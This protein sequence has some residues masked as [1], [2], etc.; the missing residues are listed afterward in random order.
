MKTNF[1]QV[2]SRKGTNS[3]KWEFTYSDGVVSPREMGDD[4]FAPDE[5]LPLWVA[6]SDFQAPQTV[7]DAL[8]K[9][10]EHGMF[11]YS[12]PKQPYFDAIMGWMQRRHNWTVEKD[13]I[14]TAPGVVPSLNMIVQTFTE[15][16]ECVMIQTPVYFPFYSCVEN[17][18]RTL[19]HSPMHFNDGQYTMNYEDMDRQMSELDVKLMI[20]CSPH[21]PVGRV[22]S[23]EELCKL[24]ELCI[25]HDVIILSDEI[26]HDLIFSSAEF[27]TFANACPDAMDRTI[28]CT[29]P[30]K[31]FNVPGLKTSNIFIP[32]PE[33]REQM[34]TGMRNLGL[35][36]MNAFGLLAL[37]TAYAT[38]DEWVDEMMEYVVGNFDYLR[39]FLAEH[40]PDAKLIDAQGTYLAWVDFRAFGHDVDT[41][42]SKVMDDAK[43]FLNNGKV[44]GTAGEGFLRINLSCPRAILHEALTR[45]A[46]TLG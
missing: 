37:K 28:V 13:W 16:G 17:N 40:L 39:S 3:V 26:H 31:T 22:W 42:Y 20:L 23:A 21:N 10:A 33:L 25:K 11:G 43:V 18:G 41:L 2:I 4:L 24:G 15:P 7:I 27:T 29:A 46:R 36:G 45:I 34:Q 19:L 30:S 38:G 32:N 8:V 35:L 5:L 6:D 44:F 1:D 12:A 9:R 14:L